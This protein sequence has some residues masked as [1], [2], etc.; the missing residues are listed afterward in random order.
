MALGASAVRCARSVR[1]DGSAGAALNPLYCFLDQL[2]HKQ[3]LDR[4]QRP[5]KGSCDPNLWWTVY[6]KKTP[7]L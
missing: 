7:A 4:V 3:S 2:A 5:P 1:A 6:S